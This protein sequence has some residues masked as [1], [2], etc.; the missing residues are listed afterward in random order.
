MIGEQRSPG[1][2]I[3]EKPILRFD[4]SDGVMSCLIASKTTAN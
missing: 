4:G 2:R 1:F 3:G